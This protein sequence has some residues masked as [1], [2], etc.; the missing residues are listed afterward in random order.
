METESLNTHNALNTSVTEWDSLADQV[1]SLNTKIKTAAPLNAAERFGDA[2]DAEKAFDR[3]RGAL[4]ENGQEMTEKEFER[5]EDALAD[6]LNYAEAQL[7]KNSPSLEDIAE[8]EQKMIFS[9][10]D[11]ELSKTIEAQAGKFYRS[12]MQSLREAIQQFGGEDMDADLNS[13][14]D[15]YPAVMEHL[16]FKYMT[17]EDIHEYGFDRYENN[18]T[19]AHNGAIRQLNKINDLAKKYH[20]RPFTVRNFWTSDL[21]RKEAQTPAVAKVMRYDRDLVEEYYAI[22]FSSESER[23]RKVQEQQSRFGF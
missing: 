16:D 11:Q 21:R 20:V 12:R 3:R 18:R 1:Q 7:T 10:N 2:L 17:P 6:D 19:R 15:F 5:W 23:R 8:A 4:A 9:T 14:S 22:A 13:A